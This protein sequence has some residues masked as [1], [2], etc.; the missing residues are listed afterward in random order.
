MCS[1]NILELL[2]RISL[3][4]C[5]ASNKVIFS[6]YAFVIYPWVTKVWSAKAIVADINGFGH[7]LDAIPLVITNNTKLIFIA[8]PNNLTGTL[9]E[10]SMGYIFFSKVPSSIITVLDQV[11]SLAALRVG[12]SVSSSE[13]SD[14]FKL[15]LSAF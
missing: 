13:I 1:N 2:A 15:Y 8:N 5:C 6:Q 10:D 4:L 11:Y 12:Y 9:L 14:F 7:D 3:C